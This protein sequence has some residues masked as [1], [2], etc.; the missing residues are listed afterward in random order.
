MITHNPP[1]VYDV[2]IGLSEGGAPRRSPRAARLMITH[3][4]PSV[5]D[6][7]IGFAGWAV[8]LLAGTPRS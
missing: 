3:D 2:I 4:P 6:V 7:I 1:S 8:R 5:S